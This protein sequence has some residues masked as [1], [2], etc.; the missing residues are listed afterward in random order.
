MSRYELFCDGASKIGGVFHLAWERSLDAGTGDGQLP[1]LRLD[2]AE[3]DRDTT[4]A[5][6][7]GVALDAQLTDLNTALETLEGA[8]KKIDRETRQRFKETFDRVNTGVQELFPRP[9]RR[10]CDKTRPAMRRGC[11]PT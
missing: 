9:V 2:V 7:D 1:R 11:W 5:D 4:R 10:R 3:A 6:V 8:I